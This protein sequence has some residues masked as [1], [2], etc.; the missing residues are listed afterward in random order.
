MEE[1]EPGFE[2]LENPA[3]ILPEQ[4]WED[5]STGG[6]WHTYKLYISF[7]LCISWTKFIFLIPTLYSSYKL[8]IPYIA[9]MFII[10]SLYFSY[11]L[12]IPRSNLFSSCKLYI[13]HTIFYFSHNLADFALNFFNFTEVSVYFYRYCLYEHCCVSC[14]YQQYSQFKKGP[15]IIHLGLLLLPFPRF[16][17]MEY[18]EYQE[19][20]I[21][22]M[23]SA[24]G[25]YGI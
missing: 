12:Y 25:C 8:Y 21:R 16:Q 22:S 2:L 11:I 20:V 7:K 9:F 5:I 4:V 13:R 24:I 14:G 1:E 15:C 23:V 6:P 3:R 19:P 18:R 17:I 10:Q